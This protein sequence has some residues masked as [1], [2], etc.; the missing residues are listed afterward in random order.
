MSH[1]FPLSAKSYQEYKSANIR[2]RWCLGGFI[3]GSLCYSEPF[4]YQA[5]V[6][7]G[8]EFLLWL[9]PHGGFFLAIGSAF[10]GVHYFIERRKS[11]KVWLDVLN[12]EI[13]ARSK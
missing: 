1:P 2:F 3:Y 7:I 11:H 8:L 9:K 12:A 10:G 6:D 4:F 5:S 13:A